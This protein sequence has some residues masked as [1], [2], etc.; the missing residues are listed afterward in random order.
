MVVPS[1]AARR[2]PTK[3]PARTF[4]PE[5]ARKPGGGPA[6][7]SPP[8]VWEVGVKPDMVSGYVIG[9]AGRVRYENH[10]RF[11]R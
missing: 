2:H 5:P 9:L 10:F 3:I 1:A 11:C 6:T 8:A 4:S 7:I